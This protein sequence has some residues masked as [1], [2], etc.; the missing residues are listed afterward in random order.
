MKAF[1]RVVEFVVTF[2]LVLGV[3]IAF[4][5]AESAR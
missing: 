2:I 3:V 5:I 4:G 1:M